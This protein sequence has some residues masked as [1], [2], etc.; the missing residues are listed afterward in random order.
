[1]LLSTTHQPTRVDSYEYRAAL[2]LVPK[3]ATYQVYS[4]FVELCPRPRRRHA[5]FYYEAM[6]VS[7]LRGA[8]P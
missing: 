7:H 1:M 5:Y 6:Q 8:N 3:V 2:I 4:I